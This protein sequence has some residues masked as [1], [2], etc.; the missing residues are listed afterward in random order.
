MT[1]ALPIGGIAGVVLSSMYVS[2]DDKNSFET[3]RDHL[4]E[5]LLLQ[6]IVVTIFS[7]PFIVL[8][9]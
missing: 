9:K 5:V 8:Y 6:A 4:S 3:A 1:L 7:I 2:T